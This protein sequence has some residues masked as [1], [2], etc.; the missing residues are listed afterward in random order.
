MV[1]ALLQPHGHAPNE[2]GSSPARLAWL[3]M[4]S[5]VWRASD[6]PRM[7]R[8]RFAD[9]LRLRSGLWYMRSNRSELRRCGAC[10]R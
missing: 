4:T 6:I 8:R 2:G 1:H 9:F 3:H 10:R 7:L 5:N